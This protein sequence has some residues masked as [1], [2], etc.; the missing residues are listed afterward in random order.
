MVADA[1]TGGERSGRGEATPTRP[2]VMGHILGFRGARLFCPSLLRELCFVLLGLDDFL[3]LARDH[4]LICFENFVHLLFAD[5]FHVHLSF[6]DSGPDSG[7]LPAAPKPAAI[8][9]STQI[10]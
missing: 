7:G 10:S 1:D 6:I 2:Q 9:V 5:D 3:A 8:A 4:I